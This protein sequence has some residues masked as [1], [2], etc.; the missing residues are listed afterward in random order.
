MAWSVFFCSL[1]V[2]A[3]SFV[4]QLRMCPRAFW[5]ELY[6]RI[7]TRRRFRN[8]LKDAVHAAYGARPTSGCIVWRVGSANVKVP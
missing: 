7:A 8:G 5:C 4:L 1:N 2:A 6:Y 3:Q